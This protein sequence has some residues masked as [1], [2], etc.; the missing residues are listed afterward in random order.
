MAATQGQ[1]TEELSFVQAL[2]ALQELKRAGDLYILLM[3]PFGLSFQ[4]DEADVN[5]VLGD[6]E[7]SLEDFKRASD[8]ISSMLFAVLEESENRYIRASVEEEELGKEAEEARKAVFESRVA[9]V[10]EALADEH[11]RGRHRLKVTSKAPAFMDIDWD[12]KVKLVDA[13][14]K[15][16]FPYATCKIKFQRDFEASAFTLISG[17]IFDAVQLNLTLDE[18][19][20]LRRVLAVIEGHLENLER[21]EFRYV[22]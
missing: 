21:R 6:R 2:E 18:V 16:A 13:H 11:L 20:Y 8:E 22:E 10:G 15:I 7:V 5:R 12:A 17:R 14:T 19:K 9:R 4:T 1:E 3:P